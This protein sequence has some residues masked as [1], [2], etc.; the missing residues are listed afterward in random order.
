MKPSK[1]ETDGTSFYGHDI[2]SSVNELIRICGEPVYFNNDGVDK[3]N[4]EWNM[5]TSKGDVFT[6]Y[7]WKEYRTIDPDEG[8]NFHIGG[9]SSSVTKQAFQELIDA[10]QQ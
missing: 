3:V 7:D 2:Y 4:V 1:Q 6:I 5:E 9:H 10:L 8:I